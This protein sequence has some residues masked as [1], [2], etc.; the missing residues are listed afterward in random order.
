VCIYSRARNEWCRPL[1]LCSDKNNNKKF[2]YL[3]LL[4]L[5][6]VNDDDGKPQSNFCFRLYYHH[7]V[8]KV[9]VY[10]CACVFTLYMLQSIDVGGGTSNMEGSRGEWILFRRNGS[11]LLA[12]WTNM[13]WRLVITIN[14]SSSVHAMARLWLSVTKYLS[15][16]LY[17]Y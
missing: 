12:R 15:N 1:L 7:R 2:V 3:F 8:C 4:L 10:L 9:F 17:P 13:V 6:S 11:T 5:F 14:A 16:P